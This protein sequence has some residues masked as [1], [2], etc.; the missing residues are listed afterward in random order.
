MSDKKTKDQQKIINF[1][2][3]Y[4]GPNSILFFVPSDVNI[5]RGKKSD[6]IEIENSVT[7]AEFKILTQ[8]FE[9]AISSEKL[10]L[11]KKFFANSKD[12]SFDFACSLLNYLELINA[13][14]IDELFAYLSTGLYLEP[15]L[16]Q[17]S[18]SFFAVK[19]KQFFK[20][21]SNVHDNYSE[22]FWLAYWSEQ[23][24]QASHVIKFLKNKEFAQAKRMSYRLPYSY[25]DRHWRR[26]S[27]D[28]L[29]SLSDQ[30][31]GIDFALKRGAL[32]P[33]VLD[34]V[35]CKHFLSLAR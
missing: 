23:I 17:L 13:K 34:V 15:S 29:S 9:S 25:V 2:L 31:Y 5:P 22:M 21:W 24:W 27:L 35:F 32:F 10:L 16:F 12:I 6:S 14:Y 18:E 3:N 4:N 26:M 1:L 19:P 28:H 33:G 30:L 7:F 8:F 11:V 20:L